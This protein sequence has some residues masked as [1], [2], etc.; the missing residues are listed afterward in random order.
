[1]KP[2][3]QL[4]RPANI[5][6]ALADI[7]AGI[8]ISYYISKDAWLISSLAQSVWH[9]IRFPFIAFDAVYLLLATIGLYGGGVVMNDVFDAELDKVERPE[10]PIP[11]GRVSKQDATILGL[12]L[13]VFGVFCGF[14]ASFISGCIALVVALLA[15]LY[16]YK[17]KH[18]SF[19]GP[20]NMGFCRGGNLLLGASILTSNLT[21]FWY[22][23]FIPIIYIAA[24]T[25][26]SR[27]EVN[28]G[29]PKNLRLGFAMYATVVL[30][31]CTLMLLV[32]K[33][34]W[35]VP[36]ILLFIYFIFPPLVKAIQ[37]PA[38]A[39]VMKAVKSGVISLIILDATMTTVFAS[40]YFGLVVLSLLLLSKSLAKKFAVT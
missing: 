26:V 32:S 27:G 23:A 1:M 16:D 31:L 28:G 21:H 7:L 9:F 19:L 2:Y 24:I 5:V 33:N 15:L 8:S 25:M 35:A 39:N 20:L 11:S 37:E 36:F 38:P 34:F 30:A 12:S 18:H 14:K 6:T 10:R 40:I 13:L 29:N 3:L 4:M 17:G 22:L